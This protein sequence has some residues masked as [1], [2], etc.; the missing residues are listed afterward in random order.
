MSMVVDLTSARELS[1]NQVG[2]KAMALSQWQSRG[3]RVPVGVVVT[4]AAYQRFISETGLVN[5][6][7]MELG[8]K[9]FSQMRWEELWD[10]ALRIRHL[11]LKTPFPPALEEELA[12]SMPASLLTVPVAVRSSAPE[13]DGGQLSFAGLHESYVH[14]RGWAAVRSSIQLVWASLWS[15]RALLYRQELGLG[16]EHSTMAVL[17]QALVVGERSGVAFSRSPGHT[18][19]ALIEAVWGLNQ[20][21]VDGIVEPDRWR[22]DRRSGVILEHVAPRRLHQW[23]PV[24][25]TLQRQGLSAY[26]AAHPPLDE[27]LLQQVWQLAATAEQVF[28]APQDVEWTLDAQGLWALQARPITAL[29]GS[30]DDER[31]WYLS[32]RRSVDQLEA[33]RQ[34]LETRLLPAMEKRT[35]HWREVLGHPLSTPQLIDVLP[36]LCREIRRWRNA[37]R[38][39]CIPMAHG[40]RLFG[41]FFNDTVRPDN[42]FAFAD[43]LGGGPLLSMQRNRD[44]EE[45]AGQL[46]RAPQWVAQ[47]KNDRWLPETHP[48]MKRLQ[49]WDARWGGVLWAGQG[50]EQRTRAL[51]RLLL[52]L[53]ENAG[54]VHRSP[55][56]AV[57]AYLDKVPADRRVLAARLLEVARASYRL[58]D[59]DNIYLG[60]LESCLQVAAIEARSRLTGES[61]LALRQALGQVE[62]LL[63]DNLKPQP[64]EGTP[65]GPWQQVTARQLVGQPAGPGLVRGR[66]RVIRENWEL[67]DFQ[68][69]EILV[70]DAVDPG[71]TLVAPLAAAIVERRGGMLIHGAIIAREY[72]L[73][74]VTGVPDATDVIHNGDRLTVDGYL[75]IVIRHGTEVSDPHPP[76]GQATVDGV[77]PGG[78][79]NNRRRP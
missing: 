52:Q 64:A 55:G 47:L 30:G 66:A 70:C 62:V 13:E 10:A 65:L 27:A 23:V 14:V 49:A 37:Y 71:M 42:P 40:M 32:L 63:G 21:L 51:L 45:L 79:P 68:R 17:I 20:G 69:G 38:Q 53:A 3:A 78:N 24:G 2:G 72:G 7:H 9:D 22:L 11:F 35:T 61:S 25:E 31:G 50:A 15:D 18:E 60:R 28:G 29:A 26:Q 8:R 48:F 36:G 34:C 75:G 46:G 16:V 1:R 77:G 58:R 76:A 33:L 41:Q 59:D 73:A 57:E 74:C 5:A 6:L 43:L 4:T 67:A 44:L 19:E 56:M 54:R 39:L 12:A